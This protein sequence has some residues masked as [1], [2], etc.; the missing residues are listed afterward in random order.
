MKTRILR[1]L[2]LAL[3]VAIALP[4]ITSA[5]WPV[6]SHS[7]Y[8]SQKFHDGHRGLDIAATKWTGVVPIGNGKVVFAGWKNNCG[9]YQVWVRHRDGVTHS[10]YYHLAQETTYAGHYVTG[11]KT[12]IGYVGTTGC[13]TGAHVHVEVW[14]GTP[15]RSGSYR[16]NPW[17]YVKKGYWLPYQYR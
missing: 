4:A 6:T 14:K 11:E 7:S 10:A 3:T 16:V 2:A 8:V 9:G 12:R 13:V 5:A 15:W 17:N 1:A